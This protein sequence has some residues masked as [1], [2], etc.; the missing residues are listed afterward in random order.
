MPEK[1][2]SVR[3]TEFSADDTREQYR[4]KIARITLDSMVQF[5]GLL[6]AE[7]T[8]LEI[9]QVALD[10][11]GI[12]LSDVEGQPFWTTYWWQVSDEINA[13]LRDAITRASQGE[14]VRWDTEI[15]GRAG[16]R[17]TILIDASLKPVKDDNGVVVFIA[18]E[19][20]DI[21][22]KKSY[23]RE[24]ARQR[25]ELAKLYE[26]KSRFFSNISQES[27]PPTA[28]SQQLDRSKRILV[29]DDNAD[30]REHIQ[31]LLRDHYEV[32]TV[33]DGASALKQATQWRP[34]LILT[35]VMMPQLDGFE[36]LR[37]VR[38]DAA[39]KAVP[40][41]LLSARAGEESRLQGLDAGA[42]D[43][44]VKPFSARELLTRVRAQLSAADIRRQSDR[45]SVL[46][47]SIVESSDDAV[48][49]KTLDGRI[50]S[51]NKGAERL[52][53]YSAAEA[54][55][56]PISLIIPPDRWNE[57]V[58][59]I[60]SLKRGER[61]DHFETERR[62]KDGSLAQISV[63][64]SP[65]RD[66]YGNIVGASK[67]A[68]DIGQ[69]KRAERALAEQARL[70]DLSNDAIIV[71]DPQ[72]RITYWNRGAQ[73]VYGYSSEE[74]LG[75]LTDEL[76]KTVYTQPLEQIVAQLER[77]DRWSGELIHRRKDGTQ[78][79][80][81]S[82]WALDRDSAGTILAILETNND[83]S[84]QKRNEQ[85][86]RESKEQLRALAES[87]E[88]K[89]QD[90]T[91]QLQKRNAEVFDLSI[92]LLRTQDDERRHIARELHDTAGQT[93]TVVGMKLQRL[94]QNA[95]PVDPDL[96]QEGEAI[97]ALI[98]KL[99]QDIRTTS[100]LLH[101]PLLDES[102][103]T[104]SL[105]WYVRGLGERSGLDIRLSVSDNLGRL[106]QDMELVIFRLIQECLTNI[107]RHSGSKSAHIQI[108]RNSNQI[109]VEVADQGDGMTP[110]RLAEVQ[111]Q[112]TG[113]GI[114]GMRER[115]RQFNGEMKIE[116][117]NMGTT[118]SVFFPAPAVAANELRSGAGA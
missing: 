41:I 16:G 23:E 107:H 110:E 61:I 84:Q 92:R 85:A 83:I 8:V 66:S 26:L 96:A 1:A 99:N 88:T 64:I 90:R 105:A 31:R 62:C 30:M 65:L 32:V 116:S 95:K 27:A 10:A 118:I 82:R 59:I 40:V 63:S 103:L 22:E 48:I 111:T 71:H 39:L 47:A 5:V 13:T 89:V 87:L 86:L 97:R 50:T 2:N 53:G 74:T 25:E 58:N 44:L 15:F 7:G 94:I 20:R 54:I 69:R 14:F 28:S 100:Y 93:M 6:D 3:G 55:G 70:L 4:Q 101:P 37:A 77:E 18:V 34:D 24:I 112:V 115:V 109:S 12:A 19:G 75:R 17:E 9:N 106:P 81:S 46:L 42:D 36:L 76:F 60:E 104:A 98:E 114:R 117:N 11:V 43:Y 52:F 38:D 35:D 72:G 33:A 73:E 57:E 108:R 78:I 113:V 51:W 68:R 67:V 80:V 91:R 49:S 102:G 79:V 21:S 29:A 45:L 56:Q